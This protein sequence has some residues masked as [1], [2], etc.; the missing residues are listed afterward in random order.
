MLRHAAAGFAIALGLMLSVARCSKNSLPSEP[1][2]STPQELLALKPSKKLHRVRLEAGA[3]DSAKLAW[4]VNG[5]AFYRKDPREVAEAAGPDELLARKDALLGGFV[6]LKGAPEPLFFFLEKGRHHGKKD[7][8]D[9]PTHLYAP[10]LGLEDKLW[11]VSEYLKSAGEPKAKE[12]LKRTEHVGLLD[13][14]WEARDASLIHSAYQKSGLAL[15]KPLKPDTLALLTEAPPDAS[16]PVE[17]WA[18]VQDCGY[19]FWA[20]S[21]GGRPLPEGPAEGILEW[22]QDPAV[23]ELASGFEGKG[24]EYRARG[25]ITLASDEEFRK[26]RG[27]SRVHGTGLLLIAGGLL[28]ALVPLFL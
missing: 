5:L 14:L 16:A 13:T 6:R 22:V 10:V 21:P 27:L 4:R 3:L 2:A 1:A 25:V 8:F 23:D 19:R 17:L 18:P 9:I 15:L 28:A 11:V 20:A 12:F 7:H 24:L 26:A